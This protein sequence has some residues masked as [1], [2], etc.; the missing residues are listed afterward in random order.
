MKNLLGR[1]LKSRPHFLDFSAA[2]SADNCKGAA[3]DKF[4]SSTASHG[5]RHNPISRPSP[6]PASN[7]EPP[8]PEELSTAHDGGG[9]RRQDQ[10]TP[11]PGRWKPCKWGAEGRN[12][13]AIKNGVLTRDGRRH[14][15]RLLRRLVVLLLVVSL[16][17]PRWVS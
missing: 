4:S 14:S 13:S 15:R 10:P 5:Q 12:K 16:P 8:Q 1:E 3:G 11:A 7:P 2:R 9:G 6:L 17:R